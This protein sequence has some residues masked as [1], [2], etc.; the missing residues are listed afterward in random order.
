LH[1]G[2][3]LSQRRR[4]VRRIEVLS[5]AKLAGTDQ[6]YYLDQ[7]GGRVD[8]AGSV[9]S[10]VE[11]YYL[12]GPEAAGEWMG[13]SARLL[14][15]RG[16]VDAGTLPAVLSQHDPRSGMKLDGPAA[17][18]RVPGFDLMFSIPKSASVM[19]GIGGERVQRAVLEAQE[20]AVAAGVAFL[21]R[22]ACRTRL[23]AGGHE[24]VRGSGFVAAAFRHRTSRAGDPQVHTHVLVIN[25]TRRPD[26]RW[27]TLD[28]RQLYAQA[29]TAGYVHEA[30]FRREL[31]RRLGVAWRPTRNG[32]ADIEGVT[33]AVIEEFSRRRAE[34]DA[35]VAQWGRGSAAARQTAALKTRARKDYGVTPEMLAPDWRERAA[36]L[37]L[38][39]HAI[40]EL[41]D[42]QPYRDLQ[43]EHFIAIAAELVSAQGLTAQAST[44]DRR[45]I[46]QALASRAHAGASLADIE[47]FA[48]AFVSR[49]EVVRLDGR[50]VP[51]P[52]RA[53][54]IRRGDG[55]AVNAIADAAR[56]STVEM[57]RAERAVIDGVLQRREDRAGVADDEALRAALAARPTLG[58]DQ[59]AMI[60]RLCTDGDGVQ[61]IVGP[62]GTGKTFALDAAREAW[63]ASGFVVSGAAVARQA[64]RGLW[65]AAGIQSTSVAALL[66]ELRRGP[67]WGLSARSVLVV[68]EAGM[69]GTRALGELLDYAATAG[70]KVA[71][72]GD[73]H[74]LPEI[75]AGGVFRALVTATDPVRLSVNRRQQQ[76][77]AREM[78]E[79]WRGGR[80]RDAM[81]IASEHGE[82]VMASNAEEVHARLVADYCE[83][84][85]RGEDAV[86][87]AQR[88]SEVRDLNARARAWRDAT[89]H[90]GAARMELAGGDFAAGDRIVLRLNDRSLNVENGNLGN[91]TE[92]DLA[93]SALIV[94]LTGGRTVALPERYLR[95][96]TAGG[97]PSVL[98]GYAGTA[99][100]T[101]GVT[102]GRAFVLGSDA[103]YREWGYVAWSR[104]R[105]ETRFYVCEP[106]LDGEREHHTATDEARELFDDVVLAMQRSRAQCAASELRRPDRR[107]ASQ[108]VTEP[109]HP[110]SENL[111]WSRQSP[112]RESDRAGARTEGVPPDARSGHS[113]EDPYVLAAQVRLHMLDARRRPPEFLLSALG[114]RPAHAVVARRW[115][116]AA[117]RIERYRIAHNI[118]DPSDAFGPRPDGMRAQISWRN[119]RRM[120]ARSRDDLSHAHATRATARD[121]GR[122]I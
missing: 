68:D 77:H 1:Q 108:D 105:L 11:D 51:S 122:S 98:H 27:G 73:H 48:D 96:R 53:D 106:D 91:V 115:D 37:G 64:A 44:F 110:G 9:A 21:E 36:R 3:P 65:D 83:A 85:D 74:Q 41:L 34:I 76:P 59:A 92:V 43:P 121:H 111:V 2:A 30:V 12:G 60:T 55:R 28:G 22:H 82:L 103:A 50:D 19:F 4:R 15:L 75:D 20:E 47:A 100:V 8:H 38:D 113:E 49:A 61:V 94:Q 69:L 40:G 80:V 10:G 62:P 78:L 88:R 112:I 101:Q 117:H 17:L 109:R 116:Q 63:E 56:Y 99:H 72:V 14:G 104:A 119:A 45:D 87:I 58:P 52:Q 95:R 16:V 33:D 120:A 90:L 71:L 39:V 81:T 107:I 32:I 7:A 66:D 57:L 26:G 114:E 97:E 35:Q 31:G 5:L 13:S 54:V 84:I 24:V 25:A 18:A 6:S 23:G 102:T 86:M 118:H 93:G 29:K 70:A 46:V 67:Q 42:V 89:G 79:L